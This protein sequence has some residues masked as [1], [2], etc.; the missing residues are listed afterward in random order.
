LAKAPP[1]TGR[2]S[3][4]E[5][6]DTDYNF[7]A[8]KQIDDKGNLYWIGPVH[9]NRTMRQ[10]LNTQPVKGTNFV[11]IR[12]NGF[13]VFKDMPDRSPNPAYAQLTADEQD[14]EDSK[15]C[16]CTTWTRT[17][18]EPQLRA[19]GD[20]QHPMSKEEAAALLHG[21]EPK[22]VARRAKGT[23]RERVYRWQQNSPP[24]TRRQSLRPFTVSAVCGSFRRLTI[25]WRW[26]ST[27]SCGM[28]RLT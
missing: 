17:E 19:S 15:P 4:P 3:T 24:N 27:P 23:E 16:F 10:A 9:M 6:P 13:R 21:P 5:D 12:Q 2:I 11:A 18:N 1:I 7:S 8:F 14:H 26:P 22:P 25:G 28:I 20:T